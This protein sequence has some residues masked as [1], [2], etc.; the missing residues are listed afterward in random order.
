M[1][2]ESVQLVVQESRELSNLKNQQ[3]LPSA[4]RRSEQFCVLL[5]GPRRLMI[6]FPTM[7]TIKPFSSI[8]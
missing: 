3:V 4:F 1:E 5:T 6:T 7:Q 2:L 8:L